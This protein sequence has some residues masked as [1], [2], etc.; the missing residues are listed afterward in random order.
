MLSKTDRLEKIITKIGK[1]GYRMTP[2]RMAVLKVLIDNPR[3]PTVEQIHAEVEKDFPMTSLA[4]TYKMVNL[5]K[6]MGEILEIDHSN[7]KAHYDGISS[8]PHPHLICTQC[9]SIIDLDLP[10]LPDI[11]ELPQ[12]VAQNTGYQI[13]HFQFN[14]FGICP[15]CQENEL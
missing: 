14:F 12:E 10:S 5:L 1:Q 8:Y 9:H 7:A 4:T 13:T 2:Q 11:G 15:D 3:H 6:E